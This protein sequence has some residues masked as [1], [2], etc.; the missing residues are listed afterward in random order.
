MTS[1]I[2]S[3]RQ[4]ILQITDLNFDAMIKYFIGGAPADIGVR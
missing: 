1:Y 4:N 3:T 2:Y